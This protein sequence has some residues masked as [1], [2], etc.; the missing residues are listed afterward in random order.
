MIGALIITFLLFGFASFV[1]EIS[2]DESYDTLLNISYFYVTM[3]YILA[4]YQFIFS[5]SN[6]KMRFE[7]LNGNLMWVHQCK[8]QKR[9]R[10]SNSMNM[11]SAKKS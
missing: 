8:E 10:I 3:V 9:K 11:P 5:T 1:M 4:S 7:M 6:I 2:S